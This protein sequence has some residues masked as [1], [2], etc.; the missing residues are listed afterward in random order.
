MHVGTETI[1]PPNTLQNHEPQ[2]LENI[3]EITQEN[4]IPEPVIETH[5]PQH[6]SLL[7][8]PISEQCDAVTKFNLE[9]HIPLSPISLETISVDSPTSPPS[10]QALPSYQSLSVNEIVILSDQMLP[11]LEN[12]TRHFTNIVSSPEHSSSVLRKIQIKPLKLKKPSPKPNLPYKEPYKFFNQLSE[13]IIELL[14]SAIHISLKNFKSMEE[15][16]LIFPSDIAAEGEALKAKFSDVVDA[17]SGYLKEKTKGRCMAVV[18]NLMEC[19]ARV[20]PPRLTM[21]SHEEMCFLAEQARIALEEEAKRIADEEAKRLAEQEALRIAE[22]EAARLAEVEAKRL[23]DEQ[24]LMV[25]QNQDI[26]MTEQDATTPASDRGKN[27][28][29]DTTPPASPIRT[30]RDFDTPSSNIGPELR[31]VLEGMKAEIASLKSDS[32]TKD[33]TMAQ[34]L[35]A[36]KDLS[37][38]LPL[39]P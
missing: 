23:A 16:A 6:I 1:I 27:V 25:N 20:D 7:Q 12:L 31:E 3:S 37:D 29:V 4:P 39:K 22:E 19:A 38:R 34:I 30:I 36:L 32:K 13:P 8:L 10:D 9:H 33:Q 28:I 17:L 14:T 5:I 35:L 24:A 2:N 26:V 15:D 21:I 18:D 11:L